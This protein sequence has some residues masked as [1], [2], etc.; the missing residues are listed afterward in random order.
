MYSHGPPIY[1]SAAPFPRK[2]SFFGPLK[3]LPTKP[4]LWSESA[5][6]IERNRL[7]IHVPK[8]H[9][10][11]IL[12]TWSIGYTKHPGIRNSTA[13]ARRPPLEAGLIQS[14]HFAISFFRDLTQTH[15]SVA[16]WVCWPA[17][18]ARTSVVIV[19]PL[20]IA[21]L[22]VHPSLGDFVRAIGLAAWRGVIGG[23]LIRSCDFKADCKWLVWCTAESRK[24]CTEGNIHGADWPF[25]RREC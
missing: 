25:W 23:D 18:F 5:G 21:F 17:R 19:S 3:D 22:A 11:F 10:T 7:V 9:R 16:L 1:T 13:V 20:E 2:L 6:H 4:S 14:F 15:R 8:I 24:L 12:H